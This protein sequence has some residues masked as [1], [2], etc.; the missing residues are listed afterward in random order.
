MD[1]R[2]SDLPFGVASEHIMLIQPAATRKISKQEFL[3]KEENFQQVFNDVTALT[4]LIHAGSLHCYNYCDNPGEPIHLE[5]CGGTLWINPVTAFKKSSF[6]WLVEGRA[7]YVIKCSEGLCGMEMGFQPLAKPEINNLMFHLMLKQMAPS[8]PTCNYVDCTS[9]DWVHDEMDKIKCIRELGVV[10]VA[11]HALW[12]II[13]A[14][15]YFASYGEY[16]SLGFMLMPGMNTINGCDGFDE[17]LKFLVKEKF[18]Q[19]KRQ[20]DEALPFLIGPK[21]ASK[22]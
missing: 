14:K 19:L 1:T 6:P 20:H 3:E 4:G 13:S 21:P 2:F 10:S 11:S 5:K 17:W 15:N 7:T 8:I 18:K 9:T 22:R 16:Y 12:G